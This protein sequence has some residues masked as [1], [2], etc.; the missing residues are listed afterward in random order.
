MPDTVGR[1]TI[2]NRL[3]TVDDKYRFPMASR[4]T[5]KLNKYMPNI[6]MLTFYDGE[7]EDSNCLNVFKNLEIFVIRANPDI[8]IPRTIKLFV[9]VGDGYYYNSDLSKNVV[10]KLVERYSG[11]FTR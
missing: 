6:K 2:I 10:K 5:R 9:V 1:L 4:I 3:E 11:R 8:E 7:F